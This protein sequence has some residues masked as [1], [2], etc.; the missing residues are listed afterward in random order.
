[1]TVVGSPHPSLV[2]S[3]GMTQAE[4][5]TIQSRAVGSSLASLLTTLAASF[6]RGIAIGSEL[7]LLHL[8]EGLV[9]EVSVP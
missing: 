1:M 6:I 3:N 7:Y 4:A 5:A 2:K 8:A 9:K